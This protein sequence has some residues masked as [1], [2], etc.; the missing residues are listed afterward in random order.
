[1]SSFKI[2]NVPRP[3][4]SPIFSSSSANS[5]TFHG[6]SVVMAISAAWSSARPA[7]S[8][9]HRTP[10]VMSCSRVMGTEGRPALLLLNPPP[11]ARTALGRKAKPAAATSIGR[12]VRIN[13][14]HSFC[15]V[16]R[17]AATFVLERNGADNLDRA[18][19]QI[20]LLFDE[21]LRIFLFW[22]RLRILCEIWSVHVSN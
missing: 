7:N 22:N 21:L 17:A 14:L 3:L 9:N 16:R 5:R 2:L 19:S 10:A 15:G 13:A 11:P 6:Y 20:D 18:R 1:M 12:A 4:P 8:T